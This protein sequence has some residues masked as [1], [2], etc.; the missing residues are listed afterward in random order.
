LFADIG[1]NS[2]HEGIQKPPIKYVY[3]RKRDPKQK[4][5]TEQQGASKELNKGTNPGSSSS[6]TRVATTCSLLDAK[7]S[8]E[9]EHEKEIKMVETALLGKGPKSTEE[10]GDGEDKYSNVRTSTTYYRRKKAAAETLR[11]QGAQSV[12]GSSACMIR[13]TQTKGDSESYLHKIVLVVY[14]RT[15]SEQSLL[16]QF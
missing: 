12:S 15:C 1:S 7:S 10:F 3:E 4:G 6:A 13:A 11:P 2:A 16:S 5:S 8:L 9:K 14:L